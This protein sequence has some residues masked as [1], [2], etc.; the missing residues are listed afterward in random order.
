MGLTTVV[1][2]TPRYGEQRQIACRLPRWSV[3]HRPMCSLIPSAK[4]PPFYY[5]VRFVNGKDDA[6]PF[7]ANGVKAETSRDV[8]DILMSCGAD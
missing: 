6:G 2:L 8:Q 5:W 7:N 3:P 4:G 1:M